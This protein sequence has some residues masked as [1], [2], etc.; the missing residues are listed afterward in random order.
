MK[1]LPA[2]ALLLVASLSIVHA[3]SVPSS[4]SR[5]QVIAGGKTINLPA[6]AGFKR[7]DG[8][9]SEA[10]RILRAA[11]PSANRMLA[12]FEP[13]V[14]D[15]PASG[16]SFNVQVLREIEG[17]EI[18]GGA[19]AAIKMRS[20]LELSKTMPS[21]HQ[22]VNKLQGNLANAIE[23]EIGVDTRLSM[24]DMVVLEFSEDAPD[25]FGFTMAM[26]VAAQVGGFT[27]KSRSVVAT[28]LVP[29]NGRLLYLYANSDYKSEA[30][31]LWA[32][33]A[34]KQWKDAVLSANPRAASPGV[35][36][37]TFKNGPQAIIIGGV[38]GALLGLAG[39]I[40]RKK[41]PRMN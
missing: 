5:E 30:D 7:T 8:S 26:N 24:N 34:V 4:S 6:P 15:D 2:P 17:V 35:T 39:A 12:F 23:N 13:E 1:F 33:S 20:K 10:D 14:S 19:F 31:R 38:A 32:E 27:D 29:V 11:L 3:Q 40:S 9:N 36:L 16:R 41:Q 22:E 25:C 37:P 18:D 21:L 28:M